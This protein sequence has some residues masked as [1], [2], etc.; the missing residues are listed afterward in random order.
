MASSATSFELGATLFSAERRGSRGCAVDSRAAKATS[1]FLGSLESSGRYAGRRAR[2]TLR[3]PSSAPT[4]SDFR[5]MSSPTSLASPCATKS[6]WSPPRSTWSS[7]TVRSST[8]WPAAFAQA[9]YRGRPLFSH[10]LAD[11][12]EERWVRFAYGLE[13]EHDAS[14]GE[15]D[16][17]GESAGPDERGGVHTVFTVKKEAPAEPDVRRLAD[18]LRDRRGRARRQRQTPVFD[19][20]ASAPSFWLGNDVE[21]MLD[22]DASERATRSLA[23]L[24]AH[25]VAPTR[26]SS[27]PLRS[28]PS[29]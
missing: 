9:A 2:T 3:C 16:G 20:C 17:E 11:M 4:T 5:T 12:A 24:H 21:A 29:S 10:V 27:R 28:R 19:A 8:S 25:L 23:V 18:E 22:A 14:D 15:D 26:G 13:A 6:T 1:L 7:V